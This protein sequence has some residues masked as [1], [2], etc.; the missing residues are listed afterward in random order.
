M[1]LNMTELSAQN[2]D[3][4]SHT[5]GGR[6]RDVGQENNGFIP[7]GEPVRGGCHWKTCAEDGGARAV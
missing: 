2:A 7:A 6:K 3:L 4:D 5:D 1:K